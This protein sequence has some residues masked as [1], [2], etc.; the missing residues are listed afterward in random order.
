MVLYNIWRNNLLLFG[1]FLICPF[2]ALW[3]SEIPANHKLVLYWS[4]GDSKL[5]FLWAMSLLTYACCIPS[6]SYCFSRTWIIYSLIFLPV[7]AKNFLFFLCHFGFSQQYYNLLQKWETPV[8]ERW[9]WETTVLG[10]EFKRFQRYHIMFQFLIFT[11][12]SVNLS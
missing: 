11:V 4:S 12:C 7:S 9:Q 10:L 6:R 1:Q 2:P 5:L 8:L 3:W